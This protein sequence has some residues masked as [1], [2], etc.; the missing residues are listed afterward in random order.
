MYAFLGNAAATDHANGAWLDDNGEPIP[1]LDGKSYD[2]PPGDVPDGARWQP[3]YLSTKERIEVGPFPEGRTW[4][5]AFRN[6]ADSGG[7]WAEHS[8]P[9]MVPGWVASDNAMLAT[10]LAE[11]YGCEVRDPLPAGEDESRAES[12]SLARI[13]L[14]SQTVLTLFAVA[15]LLGLVRLSSASLR[16]NAGTDWQSGIMGNATANPANFMALTATATAEAAGDTTLSGEIVTASGGLIRKSATYAHTTGTSTYTL[17]ATFTANG[18]DSLPVTVK[19]VGL[20]NASSS[21]T[22]AFEKTITDTLFA[23]SGDAATVT[24]TITP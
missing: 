23:A 6:I 2:L 3:A 24:Y 18:N 12:S 16:T 22:L 8:K 17:T 13:V 20:L 21:G 10:A 5:E 9:G 14:G 15:L 19:K 7:I 4:L 11:Q 1:E